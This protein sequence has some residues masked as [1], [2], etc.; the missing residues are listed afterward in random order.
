MDRA[1]EAIGKENR[2]EAVNELAY[3]VEDWKGH[4]IDHFGE[5][6]LFGAYTVL[7]GEG[8]KEVEREVCGIFDSLDSR[9]RALIL[10]AGPQFPPLLIRKKCDVAILQA[11]GLWF[12]RIPRERS[13]SELQRIPEEP[14]EGERHVPLPLETRSKRA[15]IAVF[16]KRTKSFDSLH[17]PKNTPPQTPRSTTPNQ[18]NPQS[19]TPKS[20]M[21]RRSSPKNPESMTTRFK[22]TNNKAHELLGMFELSGP[23]ASSRVDLTESPSPPT[24][25]KVGFSHKLRQWSPKVSHLPSKLAEKS[26]IY[27]PH[28]Q[29]D[30]YEGMQEHEHLLEFNGM[31]KRNAALLFSHTPLP[32]PLPSFSPRKMPRA[33]E[34]HDEPF[35]PISPTEIEKIDFVHA[36]AD[37][38]ALERP[39]NEQY[40]VYLFERILLCCKEINPN[41]PKNKMLSTTKPLVD[42]KGKPKLQLKGRIFMQNVTDVVTL[43]RRGMVFLFSLS[44]MLPSNHHLDQQ[45]YTLQIFWKG[46]PGVENFVIRFSDEASMKKW[47]ETVQAQKKY[48]NEVQRGSGQT[49]T[50]ATEFS[51][52]KGQPPPEN[53]YREIEE[54]DEDDLSSSQNLGQGKSM[55][56]VSRNASSNSLRSMQ[57]A[58]MAPPRFAPSEQGNGM[59][60]PPLSLNTNIPPGTGSPAEFAGNSYFSPS[61][62]SPVSTRSSSQQSMYSFPAASQMGGERYIREDNKHRTAPAIGRAPSR[63]GP[64][65]SNSYVVNGRTVTRPSLSAMAASQYPQQQLASTQSRSRSASTPDIHNANAPGARRQGNGLYPPTE[66]VPVPPIPAHMAQMRAPINRSQTASPI[67]IQMP[68]RSTTQSPAL[69][70]DRPRQ[71]QGQ[72]N[73]D[74]QGH[75]VQPNSDPEALG[76]L[77]DSYHEMSMPLGQDVTSPADSDNGIPYPAQ[78]K[79]KIRFDPYPSHVT[80]VVPTS[81]KHRSLIDRIDSKMVKVST[82][83]IAKG[84]A[85]LRYKDSDGDIVTIRSDEDVHLAIEDW[86]TENE[87]SIRAGSIPDFQLSWYQN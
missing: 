40:K 17:T 9:S 49:G 11:I 33:V 1:D 2:L 45:S 70:R 86:G 58:R 39:L 32:T 47:Q 26:P 51:Y 77:Q 82:A 52:L 4:K 36:E 19:T 71:Y 87:E 21:R 67:D 42:K 56:S 16:F 50:S 83:S 27:I 15:K 57:T 34:S 80:I 25:S 54:V 75:R 74:H 48:L 61:N 72:L 5:L 28:W 31:F 18:R 13:M 69:Q 73:Y 79:V 22:H 38:M 41:K 55:F 6:L 66:N 35:V 53:P 64:G 46:D 62:D 12:L 76:P 60:A 10:A 8:A 68:I 7:K 59:Y 78:L 20:T 84:T 44:G 43:N 29:E 81:I 63:E 24:S 3:R 85:R 30:I 65:P 37:C 14:E 23:A